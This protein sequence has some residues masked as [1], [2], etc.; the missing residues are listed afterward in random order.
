MCVS[1]RRPIISL[2]ALTLAEA[3]RGQAGVTTN[4]PSPSVFQPSSSPSGGSAP[5]SPSP[6]RRPIVLPVVATTSGAAAEEDR[7]YLDGMRL[8]VQEIDGDGGVNGRPLALAISD[9]GGDQARQTTL[10]DGALDDRPVASLAVGP[11]P[12]LSPL[13][14]RFGETGTPVVLLGGDLYT[15]RGLF[16][17]VFQTTIP[18]EWQAHVI[19]RYVV[20]DR[21]ADRVAFLGMGPE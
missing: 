13:R 21:R 19:A 20:R 11:G 8:A 16:P 12:A 9:D 3:C 15:G 1:M 4:S 5:A 2:L 14:A 18:W 7:S 6:S 10:L 17:Q